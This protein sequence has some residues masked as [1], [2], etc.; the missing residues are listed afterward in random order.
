[1]RIYVRHSADG[2]AHRHSHTQLTD[3]G[4]VNIAF[5]YEVVH[6]GYSCY[7]GAVVEGV[8]LYYRRADFYRHV[9]D[10]TSDSGSDKSVALGGVVFAHTLA[11]NCE[12][13]VCG[14]KFAKC[15]LVCGFGG[16]VFLTA[17]YFFVKQAFVAFVFVFGVSE[18]YAGAFNAALR[19]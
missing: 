12:R 3:F 11:H 6:V 13:V 16:F 9:E 10:E 19:R 2:D 15:L 14:V 18:R 7:G 4:F 17:D 5:E 1:M 8:R